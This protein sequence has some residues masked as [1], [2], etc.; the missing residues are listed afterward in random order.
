MM[1]GS[2]S[3]VTEY[4]TVATPSSVSVPVDFADQTRTPAQSLG[5][6]LNPARLI[7][8]KVILPP[9]MDETIVW[10]FLPRSRT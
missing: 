8:G 3:E 4:R 2:G 5:Y 6:S 9:A 1:P 10:M 7:N